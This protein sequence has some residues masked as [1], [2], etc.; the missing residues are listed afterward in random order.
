[1]SRSSSL[2]TSGAADELGLGLD[3]DRA[4]RADRIGDP[5]RLDRAVGLEPGPPAGARGALA[6]QHLSGLGGLLEAGGGVDGLSR[7]AQVPGPLHG[8]DLAGL[9]PDAHGELAVEL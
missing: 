7:D 8:E 6:D 9:D 3:C 2:P 4:V 1:M 5:L